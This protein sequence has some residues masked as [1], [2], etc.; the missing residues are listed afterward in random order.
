M[1]A[2]CSVV[3]LPIVLSKIWNYGY[4]K[5]AKRTYSALSRGL[6][7]RMPFPGNRIFYKKIREISCPEHSGTSSSQSRLSTGI[8]DCH[9]KTIQDFFRMVLSSPVLSGIFP[10]FFLYCSEQEDQTF[11][12]TAIREWSPVLSSLVS[13]GTQLG[14]ADLQQMCLANNEILMS[15]L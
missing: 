3:L 7:S 9:F 4:C 12:V 1:D 6:L 15:K 11:V 10:E 5:T 13:F 2:A 8:R 14:N